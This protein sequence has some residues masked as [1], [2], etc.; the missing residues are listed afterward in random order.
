MTFEERLG[1]YSSDAAARTSVER[2]CWSSEEVEVGGG[3]LRGVPPLWM[4][5]PS[6]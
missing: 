3:G 1:P 6:C 2:Q 5:R 4:A